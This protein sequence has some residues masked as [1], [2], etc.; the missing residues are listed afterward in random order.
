MSVN[1][2][3]NIIFEEVKSKIEYGI[4]TR[5]IDELYYHVNGNKVLLDGYFNLFNVDQY[6]KMTNIH[7][8]F[9]KYSAKGYTELRLMNGDEC[10]SIQ[11]IDDDSEQI[12]E[13]PYEEFSHGFYWLELTRSNNEQS[14]E[15]KSFTGAVYAEGETAQMP[16]IT[17]GFC[18]YK[19]EK[20]M[21]EN[22]KRIQFC[23]DRE[24][25][26]KPYLKTIVVDQGK[27]FTEYYQR[28]I[29]C[30]LPKWTRVYENKNY[31]GSSGFAR[32]IIEFNENNYYKK[33]THLLI[34]DDDAEMGIDSLVRIYGL[35]IYL[36]D[37]YKNCRFGGELFRND[38]PYILNARGEFSNGIQTITPHHLA[39]MRKKKEVLAILKSFN[40]KTA[41][42][43][44]WCICY[45]RAIIRDTLPLPLFIHSD[46]LC[47]EEGQKKNDLIFLNG[48]S[49]W[50]NG[51]E[52]TNGG[53]NTYY[54]VRNKLIELS[55]YHKYI[56][57]GT[58]FKWLIK[59][60]VVSLMTYRYDEAMLVKRAVEDYLKGPTWLNTIDAETYN[61]S[62]RM[63]LNASEVID[64]QC[65]KEIRSYIKKM[66]DEETLKA[67]KHYNDPNKGNG[68]WLEKI[69][70]NGIM[71]PV[72]YRYKIL[73]LIDLPFKAYK[74][75]QVIYINP[76]NMTYKIY[77]RSLKKMLNIIGKYFIVL[78][79]L[80]KEYK[81]IATEYEDKLKWMT[82]ID[83]WRQKLG[84]DV[85]KGEGYEWHN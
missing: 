80:I 48:F 36:K 40:M 60:A 21:A 32:A 15:K 44:W 3:Q 63:M 17:V 78:T 57:R 7:N 59:V 70:F 79:G 14:D 82:N 6:K 69:S 1:K 31:G 81:D 47:F 10:I 8:V 27:T 71:F 72:R 2:I 35:L 42:S 53:I 66:T 46:D 68:Y 75:E 37:E 30:D 74:S 24:E 25:Y 67:L 9:L 26:L 33:S 4:C 73:T 77:I 54:N 84:R 56:S 61:E 49:V 43:G 83:A 64:K 19:R 55:L 23:L 34:M 76:T 65:E 12:V 51:F 52:F 85:G 18:T 20:L 22:L 50:H 41:Y 62:L 5:E 45:P 29:N 38:I 16:Y 58:I 28:N 39:D 13:Y 11:K